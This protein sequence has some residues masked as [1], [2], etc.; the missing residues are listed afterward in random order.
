MELIDFFREKKFFGCDRMSIRPHIQTKKLKN[1]AGS[2]GI[3]FDPEEVAVLIDDSAFGS[4]K[5]GVLVCDNR[6]IFREVFARPVTYK[7]AGIE[8]ISCVKRK[9]VINGNEV[10]KLAVPDRDELSLFFRLLGE[11]ISTYGGSTSRRARVAAEDAVASD[12]GALIE[13]FLIRSALDIKSDKVYV[14]P[15]IPA[16]KIQSAVDAY[17]NGM[18]LEDVIMLADDTVFGSAKEGVLITKDGIYIK[19]LMDSSRAFGWDM[20]ESI[21]IEGRLIYINGTKLA[22]MTRLNECDLGVFFDDIHE[23]LNA[24]GLA[25]KQALLNKLPCPEGVED[26]RLHAAENRPASNSVESEVE[27]NRLELDLPGDPITIAGEGVETVDATD[28]KLMG[29]VSSFIENN[30]S[31]IVPL[32]LQAAGDG[33][34]AA[35]QDDTNILRL[36]EYLYGRLPSVVRLAVTDAAFHQ[37]M[38]RNREKLLGALL[39]GSDSSEMPPQA[40]TLEA[41]PDDIKAMGLAVQAEVIADHP[42]QCVTELV[43]AGVPEVTRD[44]TAKDKLLGYVA[45]AI[46]QNKSKI[47]P[48]LK[49]KTGEASLAVLRDDSNV[50]KLAGFIYAF[51]PGLVRLALKEQV[52]VQFML[53]NRDK[54][55]AGL[56]PIEANVE[57]SLEDISGVYGRAENG[58]ELSPKK[59]KKL[60]AF[61]RGGQVSTVARPSFYSRSL[62]ECEQFISE[63][64]QEVKSANRSLQ[65][66]AKFK[67]YVRTYHITKYCAATLSLSIEALTKIRDRLSLSDQAERSAFE[68]DSVIFVM[69][70][71]ATTSMNFLLRSEAGYDEDQTINLLAP[72]LDALIVSYASDLLGD[73]AAKTLRGTV[74][75]YERVSESEAMKSYKMMSG[76]FAKNIERQDGESLSGNF[77]NFVVSSSVDAFSD[78]DDRFELSFKMASDEGRQVVLSVLAELDVQLESALVQHLEDRSSW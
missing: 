72:V 11:W 69:L 9:V 25:A 77:K 60:A 20:V 63:F 21:D 44:T 17:G 78:P 64:S 42:E 15:N 35:L 68:L 19:A 29:Y 65:N 10:A 51:L 3:D 55:L 22:E 30:K 18:R 12:V 76:F 7:Y 39:S 13:P 23:F 43:G 32:L 48:F 75:P 66:S 27:S 45:I 52:F 67:E 61:A 6:L 47:L 37:F 5:E 31:K 34:R 8:S 49:E 53:D 71:Y 1:A 59:P 46:E 38:L 50:E 41:I 40:S 74:N 33:S 24:D 73:S 2:F 62:G 4:G 28:S 16:K 14:R 54:V 56:L 57:L 26:I 58:I 70:S 36:S